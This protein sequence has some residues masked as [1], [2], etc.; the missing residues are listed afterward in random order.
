[1]VLL[2]LWHCCC[3]W[4]WWGNRFTLYTD[5]RAIEYVVCRQRTWRRI[6][7]AASHNRKFPLKTTKFLSIINFA[8][9][10][11]TLNNLTYYVLK[12][13]LWWCSGAFLLSIQIRSKWKCSWKILDKNWLRINW[14]FCRF[15][16]FPFDRELLSYHR[17]LWNFCI[18]AFELL[19]AFQVTLESAHVVAP[20]GTESVDFSVLH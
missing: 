2:L 13:V 16:S 9:V 12:E 17:L 10:A 20:R 4:W 19:A 6:M 14:T 7:I 15:I 1:M 5:S 11:W 8:E 3:W 18:L